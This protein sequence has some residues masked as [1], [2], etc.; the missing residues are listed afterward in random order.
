LEG[1]NRI[2]QIAT[3]EADATQSICDFFPGINLHLKIVPPE[4][5]EL[6]KGASVSLADAAG[7]PRPFSS[8]GHGAQRSVHMALIKLLASYASAAGNGATVV[9]LIDEPELYLHPQAI[10]ILREALKTLATQGFQVIFSTHSPLL[11]G[12]EDV[13]NTTMVLKDQTG[14][15]VRQ[16]L[17]TAAATL[18]ANPHQTSVTF[19]LQNSSNLLFSES[20]LL[21]E[22]KTEKMVLPEIFRQVTGH[23]LAHQKRC[24][25]ETGS[26]DS[27]D[28]TTR[29]LRAVGFG[30]RACVDL[31]FV[32]KKAP[33]LN[34]VNPADPDFQVCHS[35]FA[36]NQG[37]GF[38]VDTAGFPTR[39]GPNGAR[40]TVSPEQAFQNMASALPAEVSRLA[41]QLRAQGF[42][43]WHRGA[44]E[45]H[46]GI[47]K[48][49]AAR[50]AF[51]GTL[52]SAGNLNHAADPQGLADFVNWL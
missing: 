15:N 23:T 11:I 32:F 44:I 6:V 52:R 5:D 2:Q 34:L 3:L 36:A 48:T 4:F 22:G 41:V 7:A 43:V 14:T 17:S 37:T 20:I 46:L 35:W 24:V 33:G 31:D 13:L 9:L 10:E 51:I 16:Q 26:S 30:S 38:F 47:Q 28:P 21:V 49:D 40:A 45:A 29:V 25:L 39:K 19:S 8:F 1:P 42:W 27:I 12:Q 18:A 50:I